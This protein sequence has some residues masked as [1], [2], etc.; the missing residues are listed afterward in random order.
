MSMVSKLDLEC[1][2]LE[3]VAFSVGQMEAREVVATK[4]CQ[5]VKESD[6]NK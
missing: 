6:D 3:V 5:V 2:D 1:S 4:D